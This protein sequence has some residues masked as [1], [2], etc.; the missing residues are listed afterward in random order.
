MSAVNELLAVMKSLRDP[1]NGCPWDRAQN[2]RSIAPYTIE[3]AY[4]VV[5]AIETGRPEDVIDELGDLLFHIIFYSEMASETGDFN[6]ESVCSHARE[7]LVRR[8][9]HVFGNESGKD[10][11]AVAQD[12]E[13]IKARE[14]LAKSAEQG[15]AGGLLV[16]IS[17][18]MPAMKRSEKLQKRAASV[19]FDW[20]GPQPVFEKLVEE[21]NELS[22][23]ISAGE[24]K[25]RLE[26]ELGDIMFSCI[27]LARHLQ[28]DPETALRRNN[29]KF[30]R[31]FAHIESELKKRGKTLDDADQP[32]METLWMEAKSN[33]DI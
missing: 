26:D 19:G 5:E 20:P 17:M 15:P 23:A 21:V 13:K 30:E 32:E 7:K 22:H 12:W 1:E 16:D 11:Q 8:H 27:N 10:M 28:I 14:K 3:E 29:R 2:M 6:F 24:S 18:A 4:E 9:P 31:R 33:A 25:D